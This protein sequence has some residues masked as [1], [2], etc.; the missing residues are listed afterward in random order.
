MSVIHMVFV[1]RNAETFPA[2]TNAIAMIN[3]HYKKIKRHVK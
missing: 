1:I 3:M 2:H